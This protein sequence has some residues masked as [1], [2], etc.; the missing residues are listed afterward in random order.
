MKLDARQKAL[1]AYQVG[2]RFDIGSALA[3]LGL[4]QL[5]PVNCKLLMIVFIHLSSRVISSVL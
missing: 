1:T 4:A 5:N 2:T 3:S